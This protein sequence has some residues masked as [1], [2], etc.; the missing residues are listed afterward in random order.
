MA[1]EELPQAGQGL[2]DQRPGRDARRTGGTT[3]GTI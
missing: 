1:V 2:H 3:R